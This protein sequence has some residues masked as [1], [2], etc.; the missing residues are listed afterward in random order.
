MDSGFWIL[1]GGLPLAAS[2]EIDNNVLAG[3]MV[4][5]AVTVLGGLLAFH[6]SLTKYIRDIA[7]VKDSSKMEIAGQPITVVTEKDF[8]D[9]AS[10]HKH[11][12]LNRLA[13]EKL[14]IRIGTLEAKLE[15]DKDEII[16]AGEARA[17]MIQAR[18]S[19][20]FEKIA[21]QIGELRGLVARGGHQ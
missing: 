11:C 20:G 4:V 13:H 7:G 17:N 6:H 16:G 12:E 14:E 5:T 18:I 2:F 8:V 19:A 9:R 15:R 1:D 21:E 3:G 10:Y